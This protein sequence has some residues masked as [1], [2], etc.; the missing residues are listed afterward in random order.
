VLWKDQRRPTDSFIGEEAAVRT[1][2][3]QRY[4]K[5]ILPGPR[6]GT[7]ALHSFNA[8]PIEAARIAWVGEIYVTVRAGQLRKTDS[9][10]RAAAQRR[11]KPR[12]ERAGDRD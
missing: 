4:L 11:K 10:D 7:H 12:E 5:H 9:R 3:G 6:R 1:E 2:Q 8:K